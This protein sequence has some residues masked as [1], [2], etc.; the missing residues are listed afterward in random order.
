MKQFIKPLLFL[1][2]FLFSISTSFGKNTKLIYKSK[3]KR[4]YV[5]FAT[6]SNASGDTLFKA[7]EF[8]KSPNIYFL[9]FL[10]PLARKNTLKESDISQ[11]LSAIRLKQDQS[12]EA[13]TL[14]PNRIM[15]NEKEIGSVVI[16]FSKEK[17]LLYKEFSLA[18]KM[19]VSKP[20]RLPDSLLP[21]YKKY[22][23]IFEQGKLL[24]EQN[25]SITAFHTLFPIWKDAQSNAEI[26]TYGFYNEALSFI[27]QS[28]H[29]KADYFEKQYTL[30]Q[31]S[32][33]NTITRAWLNQ[34]DSV[35][36]LLKGD[37]ALFQPLFKSNIQDAGGLETYFNNINKQL[38]DL[39]TST[40]SNYNKQIMSFLEKGSYSNYKFSLYVD[41]LCRMLTY[42][43]SLVVISAI[44]SI[45]PESLHQ[46]PLKEKELSN[47]GWLSGF[48]ELVKVLNENL[49]VNH[50]LFNSQILA[51]LQQQDSLQKQPY[52]QLF[53][54]FP[55]LPGDP[56]AF[57]ASLDK[58]MQKCT[59]V[60]WL[61]RLELWNISARFQ[62][63]NLNVRYLHEINKG[64]RMINRGKW[65]EAAN[66]FNIIKRQANLVAMPWYYSGLIKY[67]Q[68]EMFSAEAQFQHA[69]ALY[70]HYISPRSFIFKILDA[71]KLYSDILIKS[72]EAI[73]IYDIWYFH[74]IKGKA[75]Y[76]LNNYNQAIDEIN[77]QCITRNPWDVDQYYLLGD[78]YLAQKDF[79]KARDAYAMTQ[80]IAPYSDSKVFDN[81]M[82]N[83]VKIQLGK[84]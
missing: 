17:F 70:P 22:K 84:K 74:Y 53:E 4:S 67:R 26:T 7:A 42:T 3:G 29:Q 81:K 45:N 79:K 16:A 68:K 11:Y 25:Q 28:A 66:T 5:V 6:L 35:I 33:K 61:Q 58:A 24:V 19:S 57:S 12:M 46:F 38:S 32:S 10:D 59:D 41:V 65:S 80:K 44:P 50:V 69:L 73:S 78:I 56:A 34:C 21:S 30:L 47:T 43:D 14:T 27:K 40:E 71:Q 49:K 64:L 48:L 83:L 75:L 36:R 39:S 1:S 72:N 15:R 54:A 9:L 20:I 76:A 8:I 55:S 82:K 23:Q 31:S 13:Q 18:S 37:Y 52:V 77:K 60:D 62:K 63:L 2:I 51:N